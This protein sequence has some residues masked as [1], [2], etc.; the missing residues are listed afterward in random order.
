MKWVTLPIGPRGSAASRSWLVT[1]ARLGRPWN[2][3]AAIGS[4]M[5]V[6]CNCS[7][8]ELSHSP[9]QLPLGSTGLTTELRPCTCDRNRTLG[10]GCSAGAPGEGSTLAAP[11]MGVPGETS[12]GGWAGEAERR[13]ANRSIGGGA[14][15]VRAGLLIRI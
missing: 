12:S 6:S 8:T 7:P 2:G 3:R 10:A 14:G 11:G 5:A 13:S 15:D 9:Q 4:G 1:L